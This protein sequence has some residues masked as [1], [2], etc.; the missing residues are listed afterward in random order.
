VNGHTA[1]P[2]HHIHEGEHVVVTPPP[3]VVSEILPQDL[4]MT[5]LFEDDDLVV[6]DKVPGMSVHPGAG[7]VDGTLVNA[8]LA[9]ITNLSGIGGV[10]RPGI[11]HR[12]DKGTSGVMV[13]A[14]NDR[15]HTGLAKQFEAR[16]VKKVY[17]ALCYGKLESK[18]TVNRPIGRHPTHRREMSTHSRNGKPAVTHWDVEEAFGKELT[19]IKIRLETGRTHQ[20]R[21]HLSSIGHPLVGDEVYGGRKTINR[22]PEAWQ[23][24]V[25]TCHRPALHA[26]QLS[27]THPISGKPCH[28]EA[29]LMDDLASLLPALRALSTKDI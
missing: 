20:I 26:W 24:V 3:A 4:P 17:L 10:E 29:P 14:K 21:V 9:K 27:L 13:V 12:L 6:I 11:V 19:W 2:K 7:Q 22:L 15:A 25:Q 1:K 5:I 18:G 8:L 23:E 28:W 16:T